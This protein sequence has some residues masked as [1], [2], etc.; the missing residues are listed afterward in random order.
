M[1]LYII[2]LI[3]ATIGVAL[4]TFIE[5]LSKNKLIKYGAYV[6]YFLLIEV[7]LFAVTE[8]I[9]IP[10]IILGVGIA[11]VI[12][13]LLIKGSYLISA[14]SKVIKYIISA[15]FLAGAVF[16]GYK[17]YD[18]IM[19]PIR[20]NTEMEKRY[21]ATVDE[22]KMIRKAQVAY[23]NEYNK[24]TP[25]LDSLKLFVMT[26]EMTFIKKEG[27][28]H[29][30]IYL[31]AGNNLAKA[32]KRALELGLIKRDTITQLVRDTLFKEYDFE[33]FGYVPFTDN[34]R[35]DMDTASI[36]AGGLLINI[37]EAKVYNEVLLNGLDRQLILNLDDDAK[38]NG[39]FP[40]L[41]VGSLEENNNNEGNWDK[42][43]DL[44]K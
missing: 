40:G 10:A 36:E 11:L 13:A 41:K 9:T 34:K 7:I 20:F 29:D 1:I 5:S 37:F 33:K 26:G 38:T 19:N 25:H 16:A 21:Q 24:Y 17:L 14:N 2:I 30:S 12:I 27:E 15:L 3:V 6:V 18:S 44:K 39:N 4:V 28:V 43:Y 8:D 31:Q 35:F 32:E 22:L 23:K 42:E